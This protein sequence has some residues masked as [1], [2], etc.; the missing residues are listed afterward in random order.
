MFYNIF[1]SR[2]GLRKPLRENAHFQGV[3][4]FKKIINLC[5]GNKK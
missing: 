5:V 4:G 3:A 2:K 1:F